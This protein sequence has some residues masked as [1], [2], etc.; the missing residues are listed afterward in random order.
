MALARGSR[1]C[2]DR[3]LRVLLLASPRHATLAT[4]PD[5]ASL[6][7]PEDAKKRALV[8]A[9][10]L[11]A[12]SLGELT[13]SFRKAALVNQSLALTLACRKYSELFAATGAA[14]C[15][16]LR[17]LRSAM[18]K[19]LERAFLT[20]P[21]AAGMLLHLM[22]A[23]CADVCLLDAV[24]RRLVA[25]A[26]AGGGAGTLRSFKQIDALLDAARELPMRAQSSAFDAGKFLYSEPSRRRWPPSSSQ[27]LLHVAAYVPYRE[28]EEDDPLCPHIATPVSVWQLSPALNQA[29]QLLCSA[30]SVQL[31]RPQCGPLACSVASSLSAA[32]KHS[33]ARKSLAPRG[34]SLSRFALDSISF[35]AVSS[36]LRSVLDSNG[37]NNADLEVASKRLDAAVRAAWTLRTSATSWSGLNTVVRLAERH[38]SSAQQ[39][40]PLEGWVETAAWILPLVQGATLLILRS[41][42]SQAFSDA[43][44]LEPAVNSVLAAAAAWLTCADCWLRLPR[45]AAIGP[46]DSA[47]LDVVDHF[48]WTSLAPLLECLAGMMKMNMSR[49]HPRRLF[50]NAFVNLY[51][52]TIRLMTTWGKVELLNSVLKTQRVSSLLYLSRLSLAAARHCKRL[53]ELKSAGRFVVDHRALTLR[54]FIERATA[55]AAVILRQRGRTTFAPGNSLYHVG[56]GPPPSSLHAG[57]AVFTV[58]DL[59]ALFLL[60]CAVRTVS[61]NPG[62]V[63]VKV[64]DGRGGQESLDFIPLVVSTFATSISARHSSSD[65][66]DQIAHWVQVNLCD[67][68]KSY[69]LRSEPAKKLAAGLGSTVPDVDTPPAAPTVH[70]QDDL[71]FQAEKL[72][73]DGE[74]DLY[75]RGKLSGRVLLATQLFLRSNVP[76]SLFALMDAMSPARVAARGPRIS[77]AIAVDF[78]E[79]NVS[80]LVERS[81]LF[82]A[83]EEVAKWEALRSSVITNEALERWRPADDVESARRLFDEENDAED[84]YDSD[85]FDL[86]RSDDN[87]RPGITT[88]GSWSDSDYSS[89]D[90]ESSSG[91]SDYNRAH[92]DGTA[93]RHGA[94]RS[95]GKADVA[96]WVR[97]DSLAS[98]LSYANEFDVAGVIPAVQ[99]PYSALSALVEVQ[100]ASPDHVLT[101]GHRR[102]VERLVIYL[103]HVSNAA[104]A[105]GTA[106]V[107]R[108]L[109]SAKD[110]LVE[111][112]GSSS[113][114][115]L[116]P[117]ALSLRQK[118][119]QN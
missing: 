108:R 30:A 63:T 87:D 29:H 32:L 65:G 101:V 31:E 2:L 76:Q 75:L 49:E 22:Q 35:V 7:A 18:M 102:I 80:G 78:A 1:V 104:G 84:G 105:S 20:A 103:S 19:V 74:N 112:L 118:K 70:S 13:S 50:E 93:L 52:A 71:Q 14:S 100:R 94:M 33:T 12:H 5:L 27:V 21:E 95:S 96:G 73:A 113:R 69:A 53:V 107:Q 117:A 92:Y 110:T 62:V 67:A 17:V 23:C 54:L 44:A 72:A 8:A 68:V 26:K 48:V 99:L 38:T 3:S 42:S 86:R 43:A 97:K 90:A 64:P 56:Q 4:V 83:A 89:S 61:A 119:R 98:V 37:L 6:V 82:M 55:A 111:L 91:P 60:C 45:P 39:L 88:M 77:P 28:T 41:N 81:A 16:D 47:T 15:K 85:G 114:R 51:G 106:D 9:D 115:V 109:E 46:E 58:E 25:A 116:Q 40:K 24:A 10:L 34:V 79:T 59:D 66:A 36:L 57:P 11:A